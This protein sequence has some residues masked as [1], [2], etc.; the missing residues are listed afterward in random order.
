MHLIRVTG[1]QLWFPCFRLCRTFPVSLVTSWMAIRLQ[2]SWWCWNSFTISVMPL[3]MVRGF[4]CMLLVNCESCL[5]TPSEWH[6]KDRV[7]WPLLCFRI[8][9]IVH[10]Q[11]AQTTILPNY[12]Q[13]SLMGYDKKRY[14]WIL[15]IRSKIKVIFQCQ[16]ML[17][18]LFDTWVFVIYDGFRIKQSFPFRWGDTSN[19]EVVTR[20][21]NEQNGGGFWR[22][23]L[24]S[25][26]S[27]TICCKWSWS[28]KPK[29]GKPQQDT[30]LILYIKNLEYITILWHSKKYFPRETYQILLNYW[31]FVNMVYDTSC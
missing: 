20:W 6:W 13:S 11:P 17:Q 3:D 10:F 2:T 25:V 18:I 22:F 1:A 9:I 24:F 28:T 26:A 16:G 14:L 27:L 5:I 21:N 15:V 12:F 4:I 30:S 19:P 8:N 23:H 29:R 31:K 7:M